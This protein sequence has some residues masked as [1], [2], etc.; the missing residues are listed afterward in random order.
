VLPIDIF[1]STYRT[2]KDI[3]SKKI[4]K[5]NPE[6]WSIVG[7]NCSSLAKKLYKF[8]FGEKKTLCPN[9]EEKDLM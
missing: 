4:S 6:N 9:P 3:T 1:Y 2:I 8:Y 5:G 7:R